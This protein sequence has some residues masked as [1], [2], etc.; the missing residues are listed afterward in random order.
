MAASAGRQKSLLRRIK[1]FSEAIALPPA[2]RYLNWIGIFQERQRGDLYRDEFA[3]QLT[4]DPA[5]F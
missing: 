5:A 2:K 4:S 1:R 3:E